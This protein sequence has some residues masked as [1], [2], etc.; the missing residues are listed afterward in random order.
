[1]GRRKSWVCRFW[2]LILSVSFALGIVAGHAAT[3]ADWPTLR[4]DMT[5]S[6]RVP[7]AVLPPYRQV[8]VV[9]FEGEMIPTYTEPIAVDGLVFVGT[10]SGNLYCI[11]APTGKI[12]WGSF[13]GGPVLHSPCWENGVLYVPGASGLWAVRADNGAVVW[14]FQKARGGFSG[15][16]AVS[17]D[18]VLCGS[19]DGNFYALSTRDGNVVWEIPVGAPIRSS[20]AVA[21]DLVYFASEDMRVYAAEVRTGKLVWRSE[22]LWGQTFRDAF[23]IV[24]GDK[25]VIRTNPVLHFGAHVAADTVFLAREAGLADHHWQTIDAYLRSPKIFGSRD[26]ILREQEAIRS[27]LRAEPWRQTFYILDARTGD[28]SIIAPVLYTG[29]CAGIENPPAVGPDGRLI[30]I[31]RTAYTNFSLGVAPFVGVGYLDVD[32]GEIEPIFHE[33]GLQ[34]PWNTFWG[35]ADEAQSLTTGGSLVYFCHQATL[36]SLDL[37]SRRLT[38]IAGNRDSWGGFRNLPW[39]LNEWHGPA[40]A[41]LVIC[42]DMLIW[43]VGSRVIALRG[44]VESQD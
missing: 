14:S 42:G 36:S 28:R 5:R 33:H 27:R 41:G 12:R 15:S 29:G 3:G 19:R 35:T 7:V 2:L 39:V 4:R 38:N 9:F 30:V 31:Y 26:Q 25:V 32:T 37:E 11:D 1:M 6:G 16:P 23:P 34:P 13:L 17:S 21:G 44:R 10:Y 22:K 40:R 43:Q 20:S 8:W 18:L 24:V